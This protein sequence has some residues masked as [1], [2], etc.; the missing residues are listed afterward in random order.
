MIVSAILVLTLFVLVLYSLKI[1]S[2][3]YYYGFLLLIVAFLCILFV[4]YPNLTLMLANFFGVGRGA[5]LL[6][7]LSFVIG[8]LLYLSISIKLKKLEQ[9]QAE[10]I[11]KISLNENR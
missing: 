11:R 4:I 6:L 8:L 1:I 10:I 5:D 3:G 2:N 7:Y 9:I